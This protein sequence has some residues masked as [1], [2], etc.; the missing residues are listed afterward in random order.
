MIVRSLVLFVIVHVKIIFGNN[1][2]FS[3][4]KQT[5]LRGD[6]TERLESHEQKKKRK[7][8]QIFFCLGSQKKFLE[9]KW[10]FEKKFIY[11]VR[12]RFCHGPNHLLYL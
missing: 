2:P 8:I 3:D 7:K 5:M 6:V 9:T 1:L 11:V 10:E 12:L 4:K